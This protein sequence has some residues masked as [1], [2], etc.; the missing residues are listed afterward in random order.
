M[1]F[2][3][4]FLFIHIILLLPSYSYLALLKVNRTII[5]PLS[6]G[7]SIVFFA[8]IASLHYALDV[9]NSVL[10]VSFWIYILF[11]IFLFIYFKFYTLLI[12]YLFVIFTFLAMSAFTLLIVSLS[13]SG[14]IKYI[15]DPETMHN[16]NYSAFN[17]KVL[18]ISQTNANDNSVPY[19]QVQFFVN[20]SDPGKDSFIDEWGVHFFQRTP[21]MGATAAGIL[22]GISDKLPVNYIWSSYSL[23]I[24]NTYVKFQIIAQVLNCILIVPA[25]IL[26]RKVFSEKVAKLASILVA[27][28]P[29]FLY[30]SFFTWPKSFVAFFILSSILLLYSSKK[31]KYT[32]AAG[33]FMGL[34]YLTHDLAILY[35][36]SILLV[37]ILDKRFRDAIL[38]ILTCLTIVV[39]W[40]IFS[41]II[42][43]KPSS[44]MLYPLSIDGIPQPQNK[45]QIIETFFNTPILKI[46]KIRLESIFYLLSPYQVMFSEGGQA[47]GR[48]FWAFSLFSIPG[49]LSIGTLFFSLVSLFKTQILK[50]RDLIIISF[51]PIILSTVIIGWPKGL[52]SLHFAETSIIILTA[53]A[54]CYL[55]G[56]K[57][58]K[59]IIILFLANTIHMIFF[60]IYSFG[61]SYRNWLNVH[62]FLTIIACFTIYVSLILYIII[63]MINVFAYG[64]K[65]DRIL[66]WL[67]KKIGTKVNT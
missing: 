61:E 42:Y 60:I 37:V 55:V 13:F 29:Y 67:Q 10:M 63:Y 20:R 1:K 47:L 43:K 52:G 27:T 21:L 18:N 4:F 6:Y 48:R 31:L 33:V 9:P 58:I 2:V 26:I 11:G 46:V 62:D 49:S 65:S 34:G 57:S 39:P 19:R 45:K 66:L 28:S 38:L 32:F 51:L 14:P 23:D 24:N 7:M 53:F 40:F 25:F 50:K 5:L 59:F 44:F 64:K 8:S 16:R 56:K 22:I 54:A 12:D 15:P 17:V 35:I 36:A 3:L 41:V 30:N